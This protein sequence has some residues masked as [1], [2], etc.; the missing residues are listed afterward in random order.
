MGVIRKKIQAAK[1]IIGMIMLIQAIQA[2][3]NP[4]PFPSVTYNILFPNSTTDEVFLPILIHKLK[5]FPLFSTSETI[6]ISFRTIICVSRCAKTFCLEHYRNRI[7]LEECKGQC[8]QHCADQAFQLRTCVTAQA[9]TL[10]MCYQ[11]KNHHR[12]L[13]E[14]LQ[15][16]SLWLDGFKNW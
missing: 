4:T 11:Y 14:D 3:S 12:I 13:F 2:I 8:K 9:Q 16:V 1:L 7:L 10:L 15:Q 6:K 5:K